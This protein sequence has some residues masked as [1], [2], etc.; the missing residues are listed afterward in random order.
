MNRL[1]VLG[2][3]FRFDAKNLEISERLVGLDSFECQARSR[4]PGTET[5]P[6]ACL[7]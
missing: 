2:F 7:P 3:P 4:K 5:R 6:L 1:A